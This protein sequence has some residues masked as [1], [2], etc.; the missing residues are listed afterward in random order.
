MV[1]LSNRVV[2]V[3]AVIE[4]IRVVNRRIERLLEQIPTPDDKI[5]AELDMLFNKQNQL[6]NLNTTKEK[7]TLFLEQA[8]GKAMSLKERYHTLLNKGQLRKK[9]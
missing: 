4:Q 5:L 6:L 8:S 2:D 9:L 7:G 1:S 3:T